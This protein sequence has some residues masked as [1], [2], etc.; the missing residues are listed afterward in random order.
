MKQVFR[1]ALS[2]LLLFAA[3]LHAE[4]RIEITQ[5]VNTAR[6]IGVVPFK[7][8][9]TGAPP[10]DISGIIAADLRNSGKFNPLDQSRLPQQPT[11]AAEVQPA[12]WTALGIDAVVVGQIQPGADG[13]YLIS[14]QLVDTSG[15]PGTVLAQNQYKVTSQWLR[16]AAHTG[17]DEIFQK[18]TGIKGAFRTR[19]AYVVQTNGGQYPYELRVSDYDGY[20]QFVVHKASQP[21]M[22][23]AWSPDGKK[24]AYVT[25]ESGRSALV[26]QTLA[27]GAI[28]K[29]ASYPG[30]NG[31]PAFS[32]DGSKLAF[33]LSKTGSLN[34]YVMDLASGQ[35]RQL[36]DASYNSTEPSWFPDNQNLAYTSDQAGRPQIYKININ[37]G[38]PQRLTWNSPQNQDADVSTDGK[39]MVMIST[40]SG[41]QHVTRQDLETGAVQ[42]LTDT[43]LDETP[44]QAPNSTMVIYSSTQ[45][46]GSVLNLVST[47]GRFK[48]RLPATDGQVKSPAW[49]PYL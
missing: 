16:Y 28:Q 21:L 13:S 5:G 48:A 36:T 37:G 40:V 35:I 10:Q 24:L 20:N 43:F 32:P 34:L 9:G 18:L 17:S 41:A 38:A 23:P 31:A 7:W 33:A 30:H 15:S 3:A 49:S 39:S 29:V 19:I 14:Y 11:S 45:G 27:T 22:S 4:V 44:S 8:Q 46:M 1:I 6:P 26:I 42:T 25:F 12:A 2:F 47:D